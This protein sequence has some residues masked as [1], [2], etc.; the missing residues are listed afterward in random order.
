MAFLERLGCLTPAIPSLFLV[1]AMGSSW[2]ETP[3]LDPLLFYR[4]STI[5]F[6]DGFNELY[7]TTHTAHP[8]LLHLA[9]AALFHLFGKSPAAYNLAGLLCLASSS[10]LL[11][12]LTQRCFSRCAA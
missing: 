3:S 5:F 6:S 12:V 11:F 4:E 7:R 1:I 10:S 8:P 2:G 9:M